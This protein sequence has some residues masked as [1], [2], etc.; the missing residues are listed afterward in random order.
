M[1][2]DNATNGKHFASIS[3]SLADHVLGVG[4]IAVP[5][6]VQSSEERTSHPHLYT[7]IGISPLDS[8]CEY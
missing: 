5:I 1:L 4:T 2:S 7:Q 3:D 8:R 6:Q